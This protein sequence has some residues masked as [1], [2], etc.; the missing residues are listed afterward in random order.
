VRTCACWAT[1]VDDCVVW[2]ITGRGAMG[3][4][5]IPAVS[6]LGATDVVRFMYESEL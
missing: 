6:Y 2:S 1:N 5:Q 4:G 3:R